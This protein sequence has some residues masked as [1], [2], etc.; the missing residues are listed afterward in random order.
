MGI[1]TAI[2]NPE[3]KSDGYPDGM[4]TTRLRIPS[5][6]RGTARNMNTVAKLTKM[7][8]ALA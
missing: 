5:E 2:Q 3:R 6:K 7:T 8:A 1:P 4:A